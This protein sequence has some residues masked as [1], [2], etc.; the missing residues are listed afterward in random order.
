[1]P[2]R[3]ALYGACDLRFAD[4]VARG[5]VAEV[6][7]LLARKL[8]A[9]LPVMKSLG[10]AELTAFIEGRATQAEAI[11]AGQQSTRRY[12]KRQTTWF[13]HQLPEANLVSNYREIGI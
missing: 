8:D 4:M 10:V 13:R 6:E 12:A 2:E 7:A 11:A 9:T 1:M 5:A 3:A